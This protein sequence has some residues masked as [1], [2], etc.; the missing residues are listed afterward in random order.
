M[1]FRAGRWIILGTSSDWR[2][3]SIVI[4]NSSTAGAIGLRALWAPGST[5]ASTGVPGLAPGILSRLDEGKNAD[6]FSNANLRGA[7][8]GGAMD[9]T[10]WNAFRADW[11]LLTKRSDAKRLEINRTLLPADMPRFRLNV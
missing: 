6:H 2:G 11:M 3:P 1:W 4:R 7:S 8:I 10:Q 9:Q 5:S